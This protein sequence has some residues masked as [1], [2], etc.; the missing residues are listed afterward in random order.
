MRET[1]LTY[2]DVIQECEKCAEARKLAA[3]LEQLVGN[4][5]GHVCLAGRI[6]AGNDLPCGQEVT[7]SH[8][9][10]TCV[11]CGSTGYALTETGRQVVQLL[12]R[13][14]VLPRVKL[15]PVPAPAEPTL[16]QDQPG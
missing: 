3:R 13:Q 4:S 6:A 10:V 12:E 15:P 8:P 11:W 5:T 16:V 7:V 1:N 14:G 9:H 2:Y